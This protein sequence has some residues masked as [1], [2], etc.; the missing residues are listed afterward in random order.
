MRN[1][2]MGRVRLEKE[3]KRERVGG[4]V[5][6]GCVGV[7]MVHTTFFRGKQRKEKAIG[8]EEYKEHEEHEEHEEKERTGE[9]SSD[10]CIFFLGGMGINKETMVG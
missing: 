2:R 5:V 9:E 6:C 3:T 8:R 7:C 1:E 10:C 4:R